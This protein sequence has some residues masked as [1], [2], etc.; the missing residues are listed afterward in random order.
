MVAGEKKRPQKKKQ[1]RS[2]GGWTVL[3]KDKRLGCSRQAS[4][5]S[6]SHSKVYQITVAAGRAKQSISYHQ[7]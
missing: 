1:S 3:A 7:L 6:G 4:G 5:P 2:N